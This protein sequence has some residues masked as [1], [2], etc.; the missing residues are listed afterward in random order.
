MEHD[1]MD[2]VEFIAHEACPKCGSSDANA[3]YTDG[4]TY[5]FSCEAYAAPDGGVPSSPTPSRSNV[6]MSDL[7]DIKQFDKAIRGIK[8]ETF[9]KFGYGHAMMNGSPVHVAP[10]RT[11]EG[12][13]V[14]Q[15]LRFKNKEFPWLG[16]KKAAGLWGQHLW[17]DSG[18]RVVVTEGELD[19]MSISQLQGN[20]WPVVSIKSGAAGAKKDLR[21]S[22]DWL[23]AFEV[24]VLCFDNDEPG[25]AAAKD[26]AL[27][28]SP[29]KA[30]IASLPLKDANDM[31]QA[32]RGQELMDALWG[33]KTYRPDGIVGGEEVWDALT[34]SVKTECVPYPWD[35]LNEKTMG[36][37]KGEL[38]TFTAGSGIGKSLACREIAAHLIRLGET[39]GYIALEESVRRTAQ[40]LLGIELNKPLHLDIR[41]YEDLNEDEQKERREA[42]D[43]TVG[44]GRCFLYDHFGSMDSDNLL[45]RIR[46]LA[47]GCGAG[48]IVLDHLSIVVSGIGDG[49][50]RR[51][52][53]N[54]MTQLR[55]LVEETGVGLILVSHLKRPEGK[56]HEDGAQTSLGQLRGSAAIAQLS[57]MVLGLERNQQDT[58]NSNLTCV[59]VLKNRF[60][61]DTGEACS[62]LYD[63]ATGRMQECI[64]TTD[65]EE[66]N[67]FA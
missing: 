52:I 22:L 9:S 10:Y 60:S 17:R 54:T 39:V 33:A 55:S 15:H 4:H 38:V 14:A 21:Q 50:E 56:A 67:P 8:P 2:D 35:G 31:L 29:G 26:A 34:T 49:D 25:L 47:R 53:D 65:D 28:L 66:D 59:R 44:S 23:E 18:K 43:N 36:L 5:C 24:V 64:G 37:R 11:P 57:D 61:G 3:V 58:D 30:K 51:L 27:V 41:D 19:A 12:E 32:G 20:K 45:N 13:L 7:L 46:Y 62:L 1:E 63:P 48:W 42:F 40:G 6:A 16:N